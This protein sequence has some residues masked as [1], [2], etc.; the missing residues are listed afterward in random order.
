MN[1]VFGGQFSSRLNL[2]LREQKG[3]TMGAVNVLE[4]RMHGTDRSIGRRRVQ[5]EV[6]APAMAEFLKEF[7]GMAGGRPVTREELEFCQKCSRP[8]LSVQA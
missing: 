5:T 8:R 2:N 4:W 3:Y 1:A 7:D 6:T